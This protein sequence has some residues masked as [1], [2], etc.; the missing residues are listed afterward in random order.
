MEGECGIQH[1]LWTLSC[2]DRSPRSRAVE[3]DL[4]RKRDED[5]NRREGGGPEQEEG[6]T[7]EE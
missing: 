4:K 1:V 2:Q 3:E 6:C 5:L 7:G